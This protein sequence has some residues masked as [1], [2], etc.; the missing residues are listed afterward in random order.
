MEAI[1]KSLVTGRGLSCRLL[2][3]KMVW[4]QSDY[5]IV[6]LAYLQYHVWSMDSG[7]QIGAGQAAYTNLWLKVITSITNYRHDKVYMYYNSQIQY[8]INLYEQ[9]K[10]LQEQTVSI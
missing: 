8:R 2:M 1:K 5:R 6:S 10:M 9:D 7:M 4:H 3:Y